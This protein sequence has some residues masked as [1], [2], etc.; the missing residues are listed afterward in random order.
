MLKP[1]FAKLWSHAWSAV[2]TDVGAQE[3]GWL[4]RAR[5]HTMRLTARR[6]S[7]IVSRVRLVAGVFAILTPLWIVVDVLALPQEVWLGLVP[8]RVLTAAAF[9]AIFLAVRRMHT[10]GD[11]YRALF[12]LLAVPTAFFLF[13]HLH[14]SQFHLDGIPEGYALGYAYLPFVMLA[15]LSVFPLT[16]AESVTITAP[17]LGAQIVAL[18]ITRSMLDWPAFSASIWVL[19]LVAAVA[20]LAS[21]SQLAFMIV[22]V[23][24]GIHDSLTKCYSRLCGEELL[25]LQFTWSSRS[26]NALALA[27]IGLDNFQEVNIRF[28]YATGDAALKS[29][30][31][32]LHDNLRSGDMLVRWT[33]NEY[34]LIL[35]TAS[36]EE[37]AAVTRRLLSSGLG[38]RPDLAPLTGSIGLSERLRDSAEDWWRLVDLAGAR[39]Q[40]A[41]QAGGNQTVER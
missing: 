17:I 33:G 37:A 9:G 1:H 4:F 34:L 26:G 41:R 29:I 39:M 14:M 36:A 6:S 32:I 27:L 23:R 30:T 19:F 22:I 7:M 10:L 2:L 13:A 8:M 20:M 38:V 28:G 35:P 12:F 40:A 16:V 24:D 18:A 11:A 31:E 21:L 15:G 25:D 5:A 3:I